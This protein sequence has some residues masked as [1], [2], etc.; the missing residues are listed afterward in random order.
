MSEVENSET[1]KK[2]QT[3][4]RGCGAI[5][6]ITIICV[7][8]FSSACANPA[9]DKPKAVVATP[10]TEAQSPRP[11]A[12]ETLLITPANSKIEFTGSSLKETNHGSFRKFA[13]QIELVAEKPESSRVSVDIET[14]SIETEEAKLT[15]HLKS[16]DFFDVAKFPKASFVSTEIKP[17]GEKGA[18]HTVTG[19]LEMHGIKKAIT[20]PTTI[21]VAAD[22]VSMKSEFSI[23]RKDF[24]IVYPGPANNLIRDEV[25]LKLSVRAPR[26]KS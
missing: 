4:I 20:F 16:A 18:T 23:N 21:T 2:T 9:T 10:A 25:V 13:G 8:L 26:P 7:V 6:P 14:D 17:G 12:A 19:N 15:T 3:A 5:G 11:A 1:I 22:A 24:G